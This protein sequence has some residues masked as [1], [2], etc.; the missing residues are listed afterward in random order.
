MARGGIAEA[1]RQVA[2]RGRGQDT[3]LAHI[4]PRE[5]A[6]LRSHGG[7]GTINPQTGL[8]EYGLFD[9]IGKTLKG[10]GN[11]V[12]S[13]VKGVGNAVKTILKSP[14]GK[15]LG[16]VALATF[17]GPGAF[18]ISGLGLG[19]AASMGLASAGTTL[20]AGGSL[21]QALI[22]GATA[23]FG[24]P[25]GAVSN[26]VGQA[27]ITNMAANAAASAGI[28]GVGAG[29]LSGQKL[30]DAVK[31]GLTA[32][33]IGGLT[34]GVTQG[35]GTSIPKV[36][37]PTVPTDLS[38]ASTAP[39]SVGVETAATPAGSVQGTDLPP[40]SPATSAD[41]MGDFIQQNEALRNAAS[42]PARVPEP[43]L[44]DKAKGFYNEY[45]SPSGIK[46]AA[47]PQAEAAGNAAA[48][49]ALEA[50][51]SQGLQ[52]IAYTKA[53]EAAMP[54][55]ISTYGP[56][57]GAG[58]GITALAGG[59]NQKP[60]QETPVQK[61]I[62]QRL[63]DEKARVAA[64]PGAYAPKGMERFGITYNDRGEITGSTPWSPQIMGPTEVAATPYAAYQ[65][66]VSYAAPAGAI[67]S[68]RPVAQPYNTS[69]MYDFMPRYAAEGGIMEVEPVHMARGGR[70]S[71]AL[72]AAIVQEA[73]KQAAASGGLPPA[74][75]QQ[76]TQV[77]SS[78]YAAVAYRPEMP[79]PAPAPSPAPVA[80]P[81]AAASAQQPY[82]PQQ[83]VPAQQYGSNP[84]QISELARR[85]YPSL[86]DEEYKKMI[87]GNM[88]GGAGIASLAKGGYPRRTGQISGPGTGTSDSIPAMLSDG[89]FVMT[90]K[91]VRGAGKGSRLAGAKK[92]Y[93]LMHQLERNAARG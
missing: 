42:T 52:D 70:I 60:P 35:F 59:F 15:I 88:S 67:G 40:V 84:A 80:A 62:N 6:I 72:G 43:T 21:K 47:I 45:I 61:D 30:A 89:E 63:A 87:M 41:P 26:F 58:L 81:I 93:A 27:G 50:G 85:M 2:G 16:T 7:M 33:A 34:T 66:P 49:R 28:V 14:I 46:E 54:G 8:P 82:I 1:A 22:S 36:E 4:T 76:G 18:G 23:Y 13:V 90:A 38:A 75:P 77:I 92:M 10:V 20:L 48:Q 71:P 55:M 91:A 64:N 11:A 5:A 74:L 73:R 86:Y 3:M 78:P 37:A 69:S 51:R 31:T 39:T 25:G 17:L 56:M 57:V 68:G 24:A 65:S 53:Y 19:T 12:K 83:T 29:L 79:A 9:F 32:G 44:F